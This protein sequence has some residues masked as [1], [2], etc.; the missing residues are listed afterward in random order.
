MTGKASSGT[1]PAK[2]FAAAGRIVKEARAR[3][4]KDAKAPPPANDDDAAV[5][6]LGFDDDAAHVAAD[7]LKSARVKPSELLKEGVVGLKD[8]PGLVFGL[9]VFLALVLALFVSFAVA[10]RPPKPVEA[11]PPPERR[12]LELAGRLEPPEPMPDA[13][14]F[15]LDRP[16]RS[17][18]SDEDLLL[19]MPDLEWVDTRDIESRV[20]EKVDT[21]LDGLE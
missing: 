10:A 9:A 8:R 4:S 15:P 19:L 16:R 14:V 5:S 1:G 11:P 12:W 13:A 6:A 21:M 3:F 18:F 7:A 2:L 17:V 20:R